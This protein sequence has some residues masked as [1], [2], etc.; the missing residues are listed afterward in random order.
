MTAAAAFAEDLQKAWR[1]G[2]HMDARG[3]VLD[4][5]L[6]LDGM[7]V[8][9]FDLSGAHLKSGMSAR[10]TTFLGLAWM[11]STRVDGTCDLTGAQ[12]RIDLR[13]EGLVT[14]NLVLNEVQVRGVLALARVRTR[15]LAIVDAV[16]MAHLTL[17]NAK[18]TGETDMSKSQI[19]GGLW[20]AGAHLGLVTCNDAEIRGRI[21]NWTL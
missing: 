1:H 13:G 5:T 15:R 11:Q 6:A 8:R 2:E 3:L 12:F 16:I 17:E 20:A 4:D 19:L 14:E 9:G 10:D 18:V 21:H 7:S